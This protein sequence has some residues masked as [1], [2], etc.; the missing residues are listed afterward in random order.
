MDDFILIFIILIIYILLLFIIKSLNIGRKEIVKNCNN[1]CPDCKSALRRIKR[2][3]KDKI[4]HFLTFKIFN[5][6]R[7]LCNECGWDGVRWEDK[8]QSY[9]E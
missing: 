9:K 1:C 6:K 3:S 2:I 7:Y 8:F 4:L 5:A